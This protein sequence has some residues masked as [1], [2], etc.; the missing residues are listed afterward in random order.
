[1]AKSTSNVVISM[2]PKL[3][4]EIEEASI[5]SQNYL[6][7]FKR[8]D[9]LLSKADYNAALSTYDQIDAEPL[10]DDFRFCLFHNKAIC[11]VHLENYVDAVQCYRD[12]LNIKP[13]DIAAT[14][15][16][17]FSLLLLMKD[18]EDALV[19]LT[20]ISDKSVLSSDQWL[21]ILC[22]IIECQISLG[23][24]KDA[25]DVVETILKI[26]VQ[27][28]PGKCS[29]PDQD[30]IHELE[31]FAFTPR[32]CKP[33]MKICHS[34]MFEAL[35]TVIPSPNLH[36]KYSKTTTAIMINESVNSLCM[37]INT[38]DS[39]DEYCGNGLVNNTNYPVNSSSSNGSSNVIKCDSVHR[40]VF[41]PHRDNVN[42]IKH[43][44][45][46]R[47][48]TLNHGAISKS[49]INHTKI[50]PGSND[51]IAQLRTISHKLTSSPS[52]AKYIDSSNTVHESNIKWIKLK[53]SM[54]K[55]GSKTIRTVADAATSTL[56][57]NTN[58][59]ASIS[60]CSPS[61]CSTIATTTITTS[62]VAYTTVATDSTSTTNS[63]ILTENDEIAKDE[64][65][66]FYLT[67]NYSHYY[68][69]FS[70]FY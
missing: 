33:D 57:P 53:Q 46:D 48:K 70:R 2:S 44:E 18:Y 50:S 1:M 27:E 19:V 12:A 8:G 28:Q 40:S 13:N 69:L 45:H 39:N 65:T 11:H 54:L 47:M 42:N 21:L 61:S 3:L 9:D 66:V 7:L 67:I 43:V 24:F 55:L 25:K 37:S 34:A 14:E 20:N 26:I 56:S 60:K 15:N 36:S 30:T 17:A 51:T 59:T 22:G 29:I 52:H 5:E 16:V 23:R 49:N 58:T 63:T 38:S 64:G 32:S 41:S 31:Q 35:T 62:T 4:N 68:F 10:Q 6:A